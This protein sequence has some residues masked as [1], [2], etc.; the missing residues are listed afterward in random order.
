MPQPAPALLGAGNHQALVKSPALSGKYFRPTQTLDVCSQTAKLDTSSE[1]MCHLNRA[2]H[3]QYSRV[4]LVSK[5]IFCPV[6]QI[7]LLVSMLHYQFRASQL[8]HPLTMAGPP[9][10]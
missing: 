5:Q 10:Y 7:Q 1:S 2:Q 4:L 8:T 9:R 3:D 6:E